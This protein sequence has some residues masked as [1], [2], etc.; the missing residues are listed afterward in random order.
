[1]PPLPYILL[2][3]PCAITVLSLSPEWQSSWWFHLL[4]GETQVPLAAQKSSQWKNIWK[5]P[6]KA[7]TAPLLAPKVEENNIKEVFIYL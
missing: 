6:Y 5:G 7:F 4:Y 2:C 1:M 3:A